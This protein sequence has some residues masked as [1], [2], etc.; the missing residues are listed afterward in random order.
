MIDESGNVKDFVMNE[1]CSAGTGRFLEVMARILEIDLEEF[2]NTALKADSYAPIN[3]RCT[4][5]AQSEVISL[6]SKGEKRAN[7]IAGLSAAVAERVVAMTNRIEITTPIMMTGGVSKNRG[8]VR[9][10]EERFNTDI[11]VAQEA[12]VTGA[13]GAGLIASDLS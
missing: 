2:G 10:L 5:Y 11:F 12:Q 3:S 4:V 9:A 7:V 1:E 6:I 13:I 8:V